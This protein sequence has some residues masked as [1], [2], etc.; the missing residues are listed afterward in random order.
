MV[1]FQHLE[2][3]ERHIRCGQSEKIVFHLG[4]VTAC[5]DEEA[6]LGY[7]D[8]PVCNPKVKGPIHGTWIDKSKP[9]DEICD[10]GMPDRV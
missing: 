3:R 1:S 8:I 6:N 5:P 10:N 4:A 2:G 7:M 9:G